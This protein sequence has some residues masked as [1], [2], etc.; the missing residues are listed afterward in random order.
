MVALRRE[1]TG[2][3]DVAAFKMSTIDGIRM[4]TGITGR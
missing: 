3:V 1:T 2:T 4:A